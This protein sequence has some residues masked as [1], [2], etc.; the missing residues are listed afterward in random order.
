MKT[1]SWRL[2][3]WGLNSMKSFSGFI[4]DIASVTDHQNQN[5]NL[6]VLNFADKPIGSNT[7]LPSAG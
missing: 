6:F 4:V 7:I 5:Q 3:N 1:G 2:Q